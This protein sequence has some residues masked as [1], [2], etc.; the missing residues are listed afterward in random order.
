M[1]GFVGNKGAG[2]GNLASEPKRIS[3][4]AMEAGCHLSEQN[5]TRRIVTQNLRVNPIGLNLNS[6]SVAVQKPF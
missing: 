5:L 6:R 3:C 2:Y 1:H 4:V